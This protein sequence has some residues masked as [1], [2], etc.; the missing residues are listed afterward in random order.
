MDI[1]GAKIS[2]LDEK[3]FNAVKAGLQLIIHVIG[4]RVASADILATNPDEIKK[5]NSND[6]Y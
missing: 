4:D 1:P 6:D 2:T 5:A 3:V